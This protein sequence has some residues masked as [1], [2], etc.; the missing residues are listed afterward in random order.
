MK[1]SERHNIN[2]S[3]TFAVNFS[4]IKHLKCVETSCKKYIYTWYDDSSYG[5]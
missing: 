1:G 4:H 2:Y 3:K 5:F